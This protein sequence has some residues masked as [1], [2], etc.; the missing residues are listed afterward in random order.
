MEDR[1]EVTSS[2]VAGAAR[3]IGTGIQLFQILVGLGALALALILLPLFGFTFY[4]LGSF[5]S[6]WRGGRGEISPLVP[7]LLATVASWSIV[8]LAHDS[9]GAAFNARAERKI[10]DRA[11][12]ILDALPKERHFVE[13]RL[14]QVSDIGWLFVEANRLRF[15]GDLV[16]VSIPR[17]A[18]KPLVK[19]TN[20]LGGLLSAFVLIK[21]VER[22]W[23]RVLPREGIS[24]L[25]D[26][27]KLAPEFAERL[28][29]WVDA[30][31]PA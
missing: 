9:I 14:P 8:Y 6:H 19:R 21:L 18:L 5:L 16:Q 13:L 31:P 7:L 2:E 10:L 26:S 28:R 11:S 27:R 4:Y 22:G 24:H 17:G 15:V 20:S 25:S 29:A 12:L 23:L 1:I 3:G 30:A